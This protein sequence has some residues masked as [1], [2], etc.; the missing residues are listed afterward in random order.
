MLRLKIRGHCG[1]VTIVGRAATIPRENGSRR[2]VT[3]STI[4]GTGSSSRLFFAYRLQALSILAGIAFLGKVMTGKE[5]A[6]AQ[7][8]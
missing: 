8:W 3:E 1:L 5:A 2:L 6:A 4:V 7:F